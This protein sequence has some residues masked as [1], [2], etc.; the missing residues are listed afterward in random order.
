MT[1][2]AGE[3]LEAFR[4][5][6]L[7]AGTVVYAD[8]GEYSVGITE[9]KVASGAL[10][11]VRLT[12]AA[13]TRTV[14]A[15][16]TFSLGAELYGAADGKVDDAAVGQ[17]IGTALA[18]ATAAGDQIEMVP[19]VGVQH[20]SYDIIYGELLSGGTE[21]DIYEASDT[22]NY[23]LG[24]RRV[25]KLGDEYR[26][27]KAGATINCDL[28]VSG[29]NSQHIAYTTIAASALINATSIVI[30]VAA[31]DGVGA[32]GAIAADELVGG[33][34]VVFPH[35]SNSFTRRITANTAVVAT[36]G[37]C[38]LTLEKPIPVAITVDV[39]HCEACASPYLD[40]RTTNMGGTRPFLGKADVAATVGQF[41]WILV[42]CDL[43]WLAP[44]AQ[45]GD[46]A[47][48]NQIVFRHDGSLDEHD[49]SDAYTTKAQ[50]AGTVMTRAA[51]GTQGAPF[52]A[53]RR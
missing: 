14:T 4:R 46:A 26:Y 41:L 51:A 43:T 5:V 39:D 7:S 13:G 20:V 42:E 36:G 34:V 29:Y 18:A 31:T 27:A 11:T 47:H 28:A 9:E 8:A 16:G 40:V 12:N 35:S 45:V 25:T 52:V 33:S 48:D 50:H 1:F 6:K 15:A 19:H 24:T 22:Q 37:E 53:L 30:D 17:V 23:A 21:Q 3:A 38:T 44:Q 49:Y 32:D 10:V 2:T